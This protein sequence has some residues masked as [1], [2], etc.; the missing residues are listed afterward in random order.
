MFSSRPFFIHISTTS[1]CK[2]TGLY[3]IMLMRGAL[4]GQKNIRTKMGMGQWFLV[5]CEH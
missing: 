3:D 5:Y 1:L 2:S 4:I